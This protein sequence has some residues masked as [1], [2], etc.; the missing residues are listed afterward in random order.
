MDT[1]RKTALVTGGSRGLGLEVARL[2]AHEGYRV[3][4]VGRSSESIQAALHSLPGT[5]HRGWA[6]DLA[7]PPDTRDLLRR[8]EGERFD[9]LINNAGA[10]RFGP[11]DTLPPSVIEGLIWLN[12]TAP[13]LVCREFV[14]NSQPGAILVNV[15]SIVGTVP[16]PGNSVYSAAKAGLRTLTECLWFEARDMGVRVVEFRPMSLKTGFHR[17]AGAEP[18]AGRGMATDPAVAARD[19]LRALNRRRDFVVSPGLSARILA[20]INRILPR[21]FVVGLMGKRSARGGY[22]TR[23]AP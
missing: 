21:R 3:T 6:L 16:M 12:F 1:S 9:L 13:A 15:T 19:L 20:T 23:P 14:R 7:Q 5:G 4:V 22:L 2:L 8:L 17:Q 11:L 18:I 10:S